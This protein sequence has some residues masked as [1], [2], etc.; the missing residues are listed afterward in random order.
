[1]SLMQGDYMALRFKLEQ[2][3]TPQL[4]HDKTQ[5]ADGYVVV[6]VNAQGIGEFVQLQDNL[7]NVVNP[8]QIAMRY[9]VREGKIKFAT[10]AFFFEEGKSDLYAQARYGEFKVAA[11]GE[12]LLKDLRGENLV[13]L[14]KTRL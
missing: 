10:N 1:R 7:A 12:L 4:T 5:N 14:S 9:R 11:N 2:D 8:Q 3:I 6:N 13:V